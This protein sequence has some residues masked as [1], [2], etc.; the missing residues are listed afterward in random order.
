MARAIKNEYIDMEDFY[1]LRITSDKHGVFDI[2]IDNDV[3]VRCMEHHWSINSFK[4]DSKGVFIILS[5]RKQGYCI[6]F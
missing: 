6:G 3:V 1:I 2:K 4:N 5:I